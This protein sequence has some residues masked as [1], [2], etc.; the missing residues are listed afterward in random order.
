MAPNRVPCGRVLIVLGVVV[1]TGVGCNLMPGQ[2]PTSPTP[3]A[4]ATPVAL[5]P[6]SIPVIGGPTPAP[7]PT[8]TPQPTPSATPEPAPAPTPGP[9]GSCKLPA[10]NPPKE[11]CGM[12]SAEFLGQVDKAITRVTEL[13][14]SLF[15]LNDKKCENCYL[16]KDWDRFNEEVVKEMQRRGF[17]AQGG[18]E[19]GVK[20]TN[21]YNEQYDILVSTGHIRRGA[22]SYRGTCRPAVF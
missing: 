1:A 10:S 17:C 11:S 8:A 7:A 6:V 9:T 3:E 21:A 20:N 16:V 18:E 2:T 15:N 12:E 13:Y 5:P 19:L 4:S 22:G 14:P